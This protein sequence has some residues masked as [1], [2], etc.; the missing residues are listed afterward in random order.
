MSEFD[1]TSAAPARQLPPLKSLR[2]AVLS[3]PD[4]GL[5]SDPARDGKLVIGT[6]AGNTFILSDPTVS[7]YHVELSR[8]PTG[9][10]VEDLGSLNGTY[11][12]EARV[13]RAEVRPG[14]ILRIGQSDIR[15]EDAAAI[16]REVDV[17][18]H[19]AEIVGTS[20][21]IMGVKA[22]V[23]KLAPSSVSVLVEG[24]TGC[25][26]DLVARAIHAHGPR[27]ERPFVVVDCGSMPATL[28]ASELFGHEKGAFTGAE[29]RHLGA[30]ERARDGTIFLDEIGEL[31]LQ[32]QPALL[33]VLERKIV[34]R[35]GGEQEIPIGCRVLAA[36]HRDLRAEVNRK[37]F[38]SDL[39][40]RLAV[41]RLLV[42][43]LRERSEDIR[44]L[45]LHFAEEILGSKGEALFDQE[46]MRALETHRWT[47]NVRE[48]KNVIES[49]IALGRVQVEPSEVDTPEPGGAP[50]HYLTQP[51]R[52]ARAS[53]LA[54]FERKYLRA[55]LEQCGGNASEAAR[56][57]RMDRPYL[58]SLLR[59]H[60]LR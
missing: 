8:T 14:T 21:E 56:R 18:P 34:R 53:V 1:K 54:D 20:K 44:A 9:V 52:E 60:D 13:E 23:L 26:K 22:L 59:R 43:P 31:P 32:I 36:T 40:F 27:H 6:A 28:V 58:L 50:D 42:P 33:G 16:H 29:R 25:G 12:G 5:A 3:G 45:V 7:R 4:A 41:A 37:L 2:V 17:A 11:L 49:A 15:I 48:L 55:L 30:F 19:I 46:S 10:F 39:Y 24:E 47:G 38:R 57:A 35:L 51:Y